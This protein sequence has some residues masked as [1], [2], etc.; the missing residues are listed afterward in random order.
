MTDTPLVYLDRE[1]V[2]QVAIRLLVPPEPDINPALGVQVEA[3]ATQVLGDPENPAFIERVNQYV[4]QRRA[5]AR[6][7]G[8]E[9]EA[10]AALRKLFG[11]VED[12]S[13][14]TVLDA[15]R[16]DPEADR[17]VA[18]RVI[19][20]LAAAFPLSREQLDALPVQP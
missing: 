13:G 20:A 9:S 19:A 7:T 2:A 8:F 10:E 18:H 11:T 3:T 5:Q 15:E 17:D 1:A 4:E 14:V 12:Q 6:S 16:I